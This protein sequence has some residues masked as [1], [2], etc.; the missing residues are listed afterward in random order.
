MSQ[1]IYDY[2]NKLER[3]IRALPE[4]QKVKASK[5]AI[6]SDQEASQIF[7]DFI[8]MQEKLQGLMQSGQMPTSEEQASIQE[9]SNKI[10][11]NDLLKDYFDAQQ[12]LSVYIGDIERI[13]F[14]SL[15]DLL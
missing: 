10:E 15:K 7:G 6:H 2:A 1:E 14:A 13:I 5:E 11:G 12:A 9:F 3:S 8:A 4:Y